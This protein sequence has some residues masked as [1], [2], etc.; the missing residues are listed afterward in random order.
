MDMDCT[1]QIVWNSFYEDFKR[2]R[3]VSSG[4]VTFNDPD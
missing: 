3:Q 4:R 2:R 1:D